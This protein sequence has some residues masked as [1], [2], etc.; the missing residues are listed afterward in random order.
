MCINFHEAAPSL[1]LKFGLCGVEVFSG[2]GY[3]HGR[4]EDGT[5]SFLQLNGVFLLGGSFDAPGAVLGFR[6][7]F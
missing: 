6:D 5:L 7:I 1:S 2:F 3:T 4:N